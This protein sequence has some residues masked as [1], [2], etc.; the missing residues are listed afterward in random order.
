MNNETS[1]RQVGSFIIKERIPDG[2]GPH[3]FVLMLHGWTGNENSMGIFASRLPENCWLAAP[4]A[5]YNSPLGGFSWRDES[6]NK[7]QSNISE[8]RWSLLNDYLPSVQMLLDLLKDE[9]FPGAELGQVSLVGFSQGG[10]VCYA[11][12]L[13]H[14]GRVKS[15]AG[16]STFMPDGAE[17]LILRTPLLDKPVFVAHGTQDQLVPIEKARQS[18]ALL[19]QAG[20]SVSYCENDVGHKLGAEC[21]SA[22][23][24][25]FIRNHA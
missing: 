12:A 17:S 13:V 1:I 25:F 20:A 19:E 18:V 3:P 14:P 10:A 16:L 7:V 22:L 11:F 9:Y 24:D 5:P 21:F 15:I 6:K 8:R 23:E 2:P 4:R